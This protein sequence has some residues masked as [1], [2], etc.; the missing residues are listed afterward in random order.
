[1]RTN[2][3]AS[4]NS[5]SNRRPLTEPASYPP[6]TCSGH[7]D[8]A[9]TD[10]PLPTAT[11]PPVPHNHEPREDRRRGSCRIVG[12]RPEPR[13]CYRCQKYRRV[14]SSSMF[15]VRHAVPLPDKSGMRCP[16]PLPKP[17]KSYRSL[18]RSCHVLA[19]E[20]RASIRVASEV[21]SFIYGSRD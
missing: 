19:H 9:K 1:M 2:H 4:S 5:N 10:A 20:T 21:R 7:A 6:G 16:A 11:A 18:R 15:L 8:D 12:L 3:P 13:R 14:V 17:G